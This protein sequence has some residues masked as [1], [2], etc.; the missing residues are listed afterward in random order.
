MTVCH[1][2]LSG[3]GMISTVTVA[4]GITVGEESETNGYVML[5]WK[6]TDTVVNFGTIKGSVDFHS[7]EDQLM[8]RG[9][10]ETKVVG[11]NNLDLVGAGQ[12]MLE[13]TSRTQNT[14]V[15]PQP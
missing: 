14:G 4:L 1:V 15:R 9:G 7:G 8:L 2:L 5:F 6:G 10:R 11:T 3:I 13:I 12:D